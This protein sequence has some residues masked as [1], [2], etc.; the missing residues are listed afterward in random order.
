MTETASA[1]PGDTVVE[2]DPYVLDPAKIKDPPKGWR[3]SMRLLGPGMITSAAI[4]GSGE[5]IT[6]TTLGA[7]VGFM[8]LWL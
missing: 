3:A 4:V 6:A 8:L 7:Q 5:L 1:R 2:G